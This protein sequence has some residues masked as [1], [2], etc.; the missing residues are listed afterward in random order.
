M[1]ALRRSGRFDPPSSGTR[2]DGSTPGI[3]RLITRFWNDPE[4]PADVAGLMASWDECE[5]DFR[6]ETFNDFT[7]Q[8]YLRA[9]CAPEIAH[10]F[11]RAGEPAQ[12]ADLFRLARLYNDGGYYIDADDRA[13]GGLRPM[14]HRVPHSSPIRKI[15]AR[16]A[17]IYSARR[18]AIP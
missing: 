5:P 9:R 12:R 11:R 15:L 7:A 1:I 10:A 17:T 8:N 13:R 3:P 4:P 16:S 6:I 2:P 18:R 14:S